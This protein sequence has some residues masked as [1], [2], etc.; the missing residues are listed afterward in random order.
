MKNVHILILFLSCLLIGSSCSQQKSGVWLDDLEIDIFSQGI[1][2]VKA[3][4][5]YRSDT[6]SIGGVHYQRGVSG[7]TPNVFSLFLNGNATRFTAEVGVDDSANTEIPL[8]FY[9][10][11]DR[12][13]LFESGE[14][15]VG[16]PAKKVDVN[17][18][19]VQRLGLLVTDDVGGLNNK[20]TYCNWANAK[21]VMHAD[22]FPVQIPNSD[23]KYILTP[24][25]EFAPQINSAKIFGATPGNPFLYTIAAT[26]KRPMRFSAEN[27]PAGLVLDYQSGIIS[28]K[29]NKR[30]VYKATLKAKNEFGEAIKELKIK[31][32]D[33]IALTP[34]LGWN[35]WNALAGHLNK[36][37]V[38]ASAHAMVTTGLRDHGWTY[39]NIDD[40][41][42]GLRGGPLDALQPNE[43]F[44]N[45]REMVD[46]IHSLGLKAGVYS[47][48][49]ISSYGSYP[50]G[51]SDFP[52]GGE[53]HDSIKINKQSFMHIGKYRFETNDALQMAEWGFDF[54]KYDWRIDVNS[55]E[56]MSSALKK[57]GRDVVFSLSNNAPF[58]KVKDWM[59]VS[60]MWRTGPDIR[61]NWNNLYM[62]AFTLD[63]WGPYGGPGHWN[64]PDMMIVG[65]IA[66]GAELHPTRLTPDE[67]YSHIS[68]YSL[69]AAPMLIGCQLDQ[70]DAFTL[71]L[72]SNDEVIEV[73]QDPLG[74]PARLITDENGVQTWVK[75]M[76]D[77]SFAVG[78]FNTDN[79][80]KTPESYFRWGD[81]TP[82]E[83]T[84]DFEKAGL[85][86]NWKLRDLWRQKDLGNFNRTF[87][88]TIPYHGVV[89]IR[90]F[91]IN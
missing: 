90:M 39:I 65:D 30:G 17:L 33:T 49:Y 41:W 13:I 23:A 14:M 5:N 28:G 51:S 12:K 76:E 44:T 2:P 9:V 32:G 55:A 63:K 70:L 10:I 20:R 43:N 31:I 80:T 62:L 50:G 29:V 71:N 36:Q 45:I 59:R 85:K 37:N 7:I 77:G 73:N 18:E 38:M 58:G 66:T 34:P 48:P 26:G 64:D 8:K 15:Q 47:T 84:F 40:T 81:E 78:L 11:G 60:N 42:Q 46:E 35:G 4:T 61:D 24:E 54:L 19:G 21:F 22:S 16:D 3:K 6:I 52:H 68:I 74:N 88:V 57:S 67:Q 83:Y 91:P 75:P 89:M 69:L 56:R 27:L 86:G 72:L 87:S 1:R 79:F 25:P 53:T 82:K